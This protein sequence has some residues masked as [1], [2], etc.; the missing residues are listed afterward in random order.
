MNLGRLRHCYGDMST[1]QEFLGNLDSLGTCYPLLSAQ[2]TMF[3]AGSYRKSLVPFLS[4]S[5]SLSG[6]LSVSHHVYGLDGCL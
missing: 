6:L 4:G 5:S 2:A 3:V 1:M